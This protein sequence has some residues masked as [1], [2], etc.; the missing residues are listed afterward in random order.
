MDKIAFSLTTSKWLEAFKA[1]QTFAINQTMRADCPFQT[2]SQEILLTVYDCWFTWLLALEK[3]L[4]P[5]GVLSA[6]TKQALIQ[7]TTDVQA[8]CLASLAQ[9]PLLDKK[10][11]LLW[12]NAYKPAH[13]A[14]IHYVMRLEVGQ[15]S[16]VVYSQLAN[17][18]MS[19]MQ[20]TLF[21]LHEVDGLLYNPNKKTFISVDD[22]VC[23][24]YNQQ[25][26]DLLGERLRLYKSTQAAPE[27][28]DWE[29]KRYTEHHLPDGLRAQLRSHLPEVCL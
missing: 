2:T 18:L 11:K 19:F 24:V 21:V 17:Q 26:K 8:Q 29:L 28:A 22:F 27:G 16:G 25:G 1:H 7:N 23:D 20:H 12:T 14:Y 9:D 3:K 10:L 4:R 15:D 13:E 6:T 5:E